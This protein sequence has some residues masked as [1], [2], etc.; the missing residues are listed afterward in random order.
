MDGWLVAAGKALLELNISN[1][2]GYIGIQYLRDIF[3]C[4]YWLNTLFK[5]EA[6]DSTNQLVTGDIPLS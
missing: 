4:K 2:G 1:I 3:Q 6:L 5:R